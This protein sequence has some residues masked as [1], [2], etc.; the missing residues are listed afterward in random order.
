[1]Q[2]V[3][4]FLD[5]LVDEQRELFMVLHDICTKEF[6]LKAKLKYKIPFYYGNSWICYLNPIKSAGVE[7]CLTRGNE[8]NLPFLESKGRKQIQGMSL[9]G[10]N[11]SEIEKIQLALSEAI[12]LDAH[13]PY[14]SPN[15][16]KG[17]T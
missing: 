1:M 3:E 11:E 8:L 2:R 13:K 16:R 6:G 15:S 12:K 9:T 7:F 4:E 17:K 5:Q 10:L 14:Q